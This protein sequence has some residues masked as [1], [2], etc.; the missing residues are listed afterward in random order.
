MQHQVCRDTGEWHGQGIG[1]GRDR[2]VSWQ[3][4][5]VE[6]G[7]T[8]KVIPGARDAVGRGMEWAQKY[9]GREMLGAGVCY[10]RDLGVAAGREYFKQGMLWEGD[11]ME[12]GILWAE[13]MEWDWG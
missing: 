7:C 11:A 1:N 13:G 6:E 12:M 2:R 10:A 8:D 5:V 3:G 4:D 9:H